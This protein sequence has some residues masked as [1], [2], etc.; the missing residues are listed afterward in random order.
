MVGFHFRDNRE[1]CYLILYTIS[2]TF[3]VLLD[4]V[5]TYY[6][7]FEISKGLGFR[8][9]HGEKLKEIDSFTEQFESYAMQ[10]L[11]GENT[12]AYAFPSTMLI[13]FLIEPVVTIYVPLKIGQLI[14]RAN[15]KVS[16]GT[17]EE[18]LAAAPMD[19]GRYADCLLDV[20]LAVLVLYFPGGW[21]WQ[22]FF[23]MGFCHMFI[24]AFDHWKVLRNIPSCT[25]AS[26]DVDWWAQ[27]M[28]APCIG[29][30]ASCLVF[31]ANCQNYGFCIQGMPL[32]GL[33]TVAWV[34]HCVV[35]M[36]IL[37]Y[38]VPTFAKKVVG[39]GADTNTYE[40]CAKATAC[41]Y[42][43]ANPVHCLR[44]K[45]VFEHNPECV[46]YM[47]GKEHCQKP[48]SKIGN[49]FSDTRADCEDFDDASNF[50]AMGAELRKSFSS[51]TPS[52]LGGEEKKAETK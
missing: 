25:Y 45:Y 31:K 40:D 49:Y 44:S 28:F 22:L 46:L 4:F 48:N 18:W 10:R 30:I 11:L 3:N 36:L 43:T 2:C 1:S 6:I 41:N 13:P 38:V 5:T 47:P 27:A 16:G 52:S 26:I 8:T 32:I 17:A 33:C 29:V 35:H 14:V 51:L 21:T 19:M 9:Y 37:M 20:I 42:F 50:Q 23:A 7:V 24:Y 39:E 12:F 34:L 15:P